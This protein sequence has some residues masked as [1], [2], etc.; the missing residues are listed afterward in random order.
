M[1]KLR[2]PTPL[3]HLNNKEEEENVRNSG[4]HSFTHSL[5][6]QWILWLIRGCTKASLKLCYLSL[7]LSLTNLIHSTTPKALKYIFIIIK[8]TIFIKSHQ[9]TEQHLFHR[10]KFTYQNTLHLKYVARLLV[11]SLKLPNLDYTFSELT[12]NLS[13]QMSIIF[14]N[15]NTLLHIL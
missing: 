5:V 6:H 4:S 13:H 9:S 3:A 11:K 7:F 8:Y 14:L 10:L 1:I 15:E 12:L 2:K